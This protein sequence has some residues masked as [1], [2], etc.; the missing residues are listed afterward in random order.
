M[1]HA[2]NFPSSLAGPEHAHVTTFWRFVLSLVR[3][4]SRTDT[5]IP[6]PA[7]RPDRGSRKDW[8]D[9]SDKKGAVLRRI[10]DAQL[11]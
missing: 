6:V 11:S 4:Y 9:H 1:H 8:R 7:D 2:D 5:S 3:L 10:C